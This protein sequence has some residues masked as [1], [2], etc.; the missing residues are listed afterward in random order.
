MTNLITLAEEELAAGWQWVQTTAIDLYNGI[1]P[2]ISSALK[3]FESSVIQQLWSAGAALI[4]KLLALWPKG[5]N[6]PN[7]ETAFLNTVSALGGN[8]L[9]AA[10]SLGSSLLQAFLGLIQAKVVAA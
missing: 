8:L 6:L 4:Q 9:P 2:V 3:L 1:S 7:L 5:L 10:V